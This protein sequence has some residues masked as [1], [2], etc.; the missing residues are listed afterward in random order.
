[1]AGR[2]DLR[3]GAGPRQDSRGIAVFRDF[4]E[5]L[6]RPD[7]DG[8]LIVTPDHWHAFHAIAAANAGKDIYLEKP[9]TYS[10]AEGRALVEAVRRN[11]RVLQVGS[12]QR[13]QIYFRIACEMARNGRVG[14]LETIRVWNPIDSGTGNPAPQPV[15][16]YLNYDLWMGPTAEMPFCRGPRPSPGRLRPAGLAPDRALLPRH[17]H[18]LGLPYE[19]HRPVGTTAR[20]T[21][22][23][24]RSQAKAEFPDRGLFDVHTVYSSEGLYA[25]GVRLIQ[26]TGDPAGVRFEGDKGWVF[27]SREKIE[28]SDPA[29]LRQKPGP[30]EI[31]L[32]REHEPHDATSSSASATARTPSPRSR[33]AT[34]RTRS[35][36]SPTSP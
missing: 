2:A 8:V 10:V 20:T 5:L 25:N 36:A 9:M 30:G 32:Y 27:C 11:K 6:A 16:K 17:D 4:R 23:R 28:A 35:A 34:A 19:R 22:G 26:Q 33:S 14:K 21:P 31:T 29:L 1:M 18:R 3:Q 13:S 12:Q 15:P 7:I 24:S